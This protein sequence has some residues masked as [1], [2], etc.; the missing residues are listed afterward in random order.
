VKAGI[1]CMKCGGR[2]HPAM[3]DA[4]RTLHARVGTPY[5]PP[6]VCAECLYVALAKFAFDE[7]DGNGAQEGEK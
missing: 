5:T 1:I 3:F 4:K 7:G 6:K 2:I